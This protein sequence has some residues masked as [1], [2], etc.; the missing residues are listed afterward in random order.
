[1]AEPIAARR[2]ALPIFGVLFVVLFAL[3][4]VSEGIG[5]PSVPEGDVLLVEDAPGDTGHVSK[6]EF[7][8]TLELAAAGEG[9]EVPKPGTKQYDELKE[10]ALNGLVE[11][12]WLEGDAEEMGIEVTPQK[13]EQEFQKIKKE[14]FPSKE[15]FEEFLKES[16]FTREDINDRVK[17]QILAQELQEEV[18]QDPPTPSDSEVE[19]YYEAAKATQFTKPSS[20]DIRLIVN[21]DEEKAEKAL[22]ELE[23]GNTPGDWSR[24]AKELSED[25][26]SKG[27]GGMQKNVV[28]GSL[29]APLEGPVLGAPEGQLEGPVKAPR[30]FVVFEVQKENPETVEPLSKV[31]G[32][33]QSQL[34]QQLEQ[35]AFAGFVSDFNEKWRS[36][37]FCAEDYMT[38][39]CANFEGAGRPQNA[40]PACYEAEPKGGR[41]EACPAPVFQAIPAV[42]GSVTPLA[43]QGEPLAQRPHPPGEEKAPEQP[44]EGLPGGA[45]PPPA[46]E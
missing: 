35:E 31:S 10:T 24:V 20:R 8:H 18:N 13:I 16:K 29:E 15:E 6:A 11:A 41:P 19:A 5:D 1:M 21:K 44:P 30:G 37:T 32:Q 2:R 26:A 39:R 45:L 9:K 22:T 42:P 27:K 36:R 33:I 4:A 40:P 7:D 14:N 46:G 34:A 43:P 23:E 38:E 28:E 12:I 25:A 3:V 17:L